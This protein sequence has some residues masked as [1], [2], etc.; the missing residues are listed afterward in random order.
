MDPVSTGPDAQ[1]CLIHTPNLA[2]ISL[3]PLPSSPQHLVISVRQSEYFNWKFVYIYTIIFFGLSNPTIKDEHFVLTPL[4][5][6]FFRRC[7][8]IS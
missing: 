1:A 5:L 7:V 2:L 6:H 8:Y 3:F 4:P